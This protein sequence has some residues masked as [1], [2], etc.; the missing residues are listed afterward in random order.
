MDSQESKPTT[1]CNL[2][3]E[4]GTHTG[5]VYVYRMSKAR[6]GKL[7]RPKREKRHYCLTHY[8]EN[9]YGLWPYRCTRVCQRARRAASE[10]LLRPE[11]M[12]VWIG[13]EVILGGGNHPNCPW[14]GKAMKSAHP[15]GE[16]PR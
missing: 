4:P 8:M 14:C 7:P 3:K 11:Q 15:L 5:E 12:V 2:C 9:Q 16:K 10:I 1:R 13:M 6:K